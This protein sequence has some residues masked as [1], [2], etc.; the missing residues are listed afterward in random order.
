MKLNTLA[1]HAGDRKKLGNYVPVTTPIYSATSFFYDSMEDLDRV[2]ADE[3]PGENYSRYGN[4]TARAFEAQVAALE[5]GEVAFST[6]SGMAA[7]HLAI[8]AALTD[9][10][11]SIVAASALY[12]Q[13]L[14]LL[15][16]L[17]EPSG[18]AVR[19]ADPCD[20]AAFETAVA[21][22]KQAYEAAK[23]AYEKA[24]AD[25]L[26]ADPEYAALTKELAELKSAGKKPK[27]PKEPK[28]KK[29]EG[30]GEGQ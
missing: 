18:V 6:S 25:K 16:K 30:A 20:P 13:T 26:A 12:G 3:E 15:T 2:F 23:S 8:L 5:G 22:A 7:L 28:E 17:L 9:R 11:R 4:P 10:R 24:L 14:T 29:P 1:V 21:E 19:F 27:E